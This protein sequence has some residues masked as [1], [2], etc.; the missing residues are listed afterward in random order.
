MSKI[1][2]GARMRFHFSAR[3]NRLLWFTLL[4]NLLLSCTAVQTVPVRFVSAAPL[5]TGLRIAVIGD[6]Q[7]T[8]RYEI[9]RERQGAH[10]RV[11]EAMLKQK[12]DALV[13]LGDM[14]FD[15]ADDDDW[16]FY[17]HLMAPVAG[18]GIPAFPIFGNHEYLRSS[19]DAQV[20]VRRRFPGVRS[21][22]Y[23]VSMDSITFVMINT[24]FERISSTMR[25]QQKHWYDSTL[26]AL[27]M[28]PRTRCIVVCGHHPPMTNSMN[29]SDAHEV[30]EQYVP[31]F[32]RTAKSRLWLSGHS[33]A[34]ERFRVEGRDFIVAGGGG[35]PRH[36]L[37]AD[38]E[39]RHAHVGVPRR[40]RTLSPFHLLMI[41]RVQDSLAIELVPVA[42]HAPQH[43]QGAA[44]DQ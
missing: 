1:P 25:Q 19:R 9:W 20:N 36:K 30:Q 41:T 8:S 40:N 39:L 22:W 35:A 11:V 14:V 38:D 34:Y 26:R 13:I 28:D 4:C 21:T 10:E 17:D 16:A 32:L 43:G 18:A 31:G 44:T 2:H 3:T 29:V 24:N 7:R 5:G 42:T 6:Q 23:T 12:P 37:M 27:E 33:H 15:G